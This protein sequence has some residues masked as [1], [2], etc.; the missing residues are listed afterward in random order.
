MKHLSTK[1]RA[2]RSLVGKAIKGMSR[3]S[4]RRS[5]GGFYWRIRDLMLKRSPKE[6]FHLRYEEGSGTASWKIGKHSSGDPLHEITFYSELE[7]MF[8]AEAMNDTL[9]MQGCKNVFRH[10]LGH[11]L[12]TPR[13]PKNL[14]KLKEEGIPFPLYNLFEDCRIEYKLVQNWKDY[15]LFYWHK[16]QRGFEKLEKPIEALYHLKLSEAGSRVARSKTLKTLRFLPLGLC[17]PEIKKERKRICYF[18]DSII[19]IEDDDFNG[20]LRLMRQ[21]IS[22]YGD[23]MPKTP[24]GG[25]LEGSINEDSLEEASE[26]SGASEASKGSPDPKED[27]SRSGG[28]HERIEKSGSKKAEDLSDFHVKSRASDMA[29]REALHKASL[30]KPIIKKA[31]LKPREAGRRG[32]FHVGRALQG[33]ADAF[34]RSSPSNGKR[35]VYLLLDMSGSMNYLW[36][37]GMA[38]LASAFFH[39]RDQDLI[40]LKAFICKGDSGKAIL[41]DISRSPADLPLKLEPNG[42]E[43]MIKDALDKTSAHLISSDVCFILTDADIVDEPV[44]PNFWRRKGVD[45]VG[46]VAHPEILESDRIT[47]FLRQRMSEHF[48]RSFIESSSFALGRR[49]LRY[50]MRSKAK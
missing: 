12:F 38:S 40:N 10:E 17:S 9:K 37:A 11:A 2:F 28:E 13:D 39:L 27:V 48:S 8:D 15:G 33:L 7:Q 23:E 42:S 44:D 6:R 31:K 25:I 43:E 41:A 26:G 19:R 16:F 3:S 30:L 35:D 32:K 29:K 24:S 21:W 18:Y 5:K 50:A 45:L 47:E 36:D 49:M 20:M 1:A 4:G 46:C 34:L 22:I 14:I